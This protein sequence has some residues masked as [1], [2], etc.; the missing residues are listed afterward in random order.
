MKFIPINFELYLSLY[1]P[2]SKFSRRQINIFLI[3][4]RKWALA[5]PAN[6]LPRRQFARI[7]KAYFL[8][9]IRKIWENVIC[10]NFVESWYGALY[11]V[12]IAIVLM[13]IL[14]WSL[15]FY[16]KVKYTVDSRYL[17]VQETMKHFKVSVLRH[18]R[19]ERV[20]KTINWTTIF[21]KW[22]CNLTPAV[23]TIYI[24]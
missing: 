11:V 18:I 13:V 7:V 15:I 16:S 23:R 4:S 2:L 19:V 24:K 1:H 6:C 20:K 21:N 12:C 8:R 9:K 22:I 17:K 3:F 14:C 5:I 10:W